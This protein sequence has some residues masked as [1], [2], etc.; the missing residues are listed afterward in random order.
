[1][2]ITEAGITAKLRDT[3]EVHGDSVR[4]K[5]RKYTVTGALNIY[6]QV[7]SEYD[8]LEHTFTA[9]VKRDP[10]K[11]LIQEIGANA[12]DVDIMLTCS[13]A[14]LAEQLVGLTY[15]Y[16]NEKDILFFDDAEYR[17]VKSEPT[18]RPFGNPLVLLLAC[19]I[20]NTREK[21]V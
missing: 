16:I 14:L 12:D 11:E 13:F 19:K 21:A 4:L 3:V 5:V 17:V 1:M 18:G 9:V 10:P 20:A 6:K 7:K 8:V 15:P 2:T